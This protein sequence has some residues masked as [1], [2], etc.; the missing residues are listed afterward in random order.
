M[1]D[2]CLE[3]QRLGLAAPSLVRSATD[4]YFESEDAIGAWIEDRCDRRLDSWELTKKLFAS[5]KEWTETAGERTGTCKRFVQT[6]ESHGFRSQRRHN[7]RGIQGLSV[8]P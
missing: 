3:W 5:W 6:L 2:S 1:V 7:G 4:D 8:K